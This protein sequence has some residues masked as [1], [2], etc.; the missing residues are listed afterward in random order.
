MAPGR[1]EGDPRIIGIRSCQ[2]EVEVV[3]VE[4]RDLADHRRIAVALE[5]EQI[6]GNG[7]SAAKVL[8]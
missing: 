7:V 3:R 1:R 5:N 2:L 6:V 4:D 8:W